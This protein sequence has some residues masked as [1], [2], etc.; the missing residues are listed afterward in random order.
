MVGW[1]TGTHAE[2]RG[3]G[4]HVHP[5]AWEVCHLAGG[6]VEWWVGDEVHELGPGDVYITRPKEPHGAIGGVMHP[7]DLRWVQL[8]P[9]RGGLPGMTRHRADAVFEGLGRRRVFHGGEPI[10]R[11]IDALLDAA[12]APPH[13]WQVLEARA[14][15]HAVLAAVLRAG[16]ASIREHPPPSPTI[17]RAARLLDQDLAADRTVAEV[18]EAVGLSVTRLHERFKSETGYSPADWRSRRR[19]AAAKAALRHADEPVT[20]LAHRLGY[21]SSQHFATAFRKATGVSPTAYRAA[22]HINYAPS[23]DV[24]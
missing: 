23:P 24:R 12:G 1:S 5:A 8:A 19:V 14:A 13:P 11:A 10:R 6:S 7:C 15:L 2:P 17:A 3:L 9:V 20:R 18:A 4:P 16:D 22:T 21:S